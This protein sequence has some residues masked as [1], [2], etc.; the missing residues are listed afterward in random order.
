MPGGLNS[1][2]V[3]YPDPGQ[4]DIFL[5][6]QNSGTPFLAAPDRIRNRAVS[7]ATT[8]CNPRDR[9]LG[10]AGAGTTGA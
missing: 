4:G 2:A 8:A 10:G 6:A 3:A 9:Q 1:A 7:K 5:D